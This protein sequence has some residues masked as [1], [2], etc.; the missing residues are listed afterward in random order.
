MK[1]V[2]GMCLKQASDK[3]HKILSTKWHFSMHRTQPLFFKVYRMS[4]DRLY[5]ISII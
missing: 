1:Q 5:Y 4:P 2:K 3:E